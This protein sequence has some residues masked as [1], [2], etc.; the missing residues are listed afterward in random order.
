MSR[1][2]VTEI[3]LLIV[4]FIGIILL[5]KCHGNALVDCVFSTINDIV[6]R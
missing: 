4:V 5:V 6:R 3:I 1:I 2:G